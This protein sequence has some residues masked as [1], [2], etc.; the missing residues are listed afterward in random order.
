MALHELLSRPVPLAGLYVAAAGLYYGSLFWRQSRG[1]KAGNLE[2]SFSMVF[3][4]VALIGLLLMALVAV[5]YFWLFPERHM[6][7]VD[8]SG[9][10]A[11]KLRLG[12]Y[13]E[14]RKKTGIIG[15][16]A[17][18]CGW[19]PFDKPSGLFLERGNVKTPA[20]YE[21]WLALSPVA[22]NEVLLAIDP[23]DPTEPIS[24][25]LEA[26]L[27]AWGRSQPDV[28]EIMVGNYH[29]SLELRVLWKKEVDLQQVPGEFLGVSIRNLHQ[30]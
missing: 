8:L 10:E 14:Y 27:R 18:L 9:T 6:N 13:R 4:P 26:A 16:I 24:V 15:R 23:N 25:G 17:E 22:R 1:K 30:T 5:P 7:V 28:V 29:C 12:Q 2:Q 21:E 19:R 20:T 3:V 11:E